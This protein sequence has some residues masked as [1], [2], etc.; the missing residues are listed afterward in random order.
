[1]SMNDHRG[2]SPVE[3]GIRQVDVREV[4]NQQHQKD[5]ATEYH[6]SGR[7]DV[8]SRHGFILFCQSSATL[9]MT[10]RASRQGSGSGLFPLLQLSARTLPARAQ[11]A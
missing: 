3:C 5:E 11:E 2:S 10:I 9:S 6:Q 8:P 4:Q 1:M 7:V